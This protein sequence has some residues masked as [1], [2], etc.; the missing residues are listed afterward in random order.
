MYAIYMNIFQYQI[1]LKTIECGSF[2]RAADELHLTQSGVSHAIMALEEELGLTLLNRG[3]NGISLTSDGL[4]VIPHIKEICSVQHKLEEEIKDL[5]SLGTGMVRIGTF[6]S[7]SVWWLPGILRDFR[8]QW[9][10]IEFE[11]L[12]GDY[13]EIE[14]WISE[15][16]VDCGFLRLPTKQNLDCDPVYS[17][18]LVVLI[19]EDHPLASRKAISAQ[20]LTQYPYISPD[21]GKDYEIDAVFDFYKIKPR[22]QYTAKD[23]PTIMAMVGNGLGISIL[24]ELVVK[25]SS[26]PIVARP[27]AKTFRRDIGLCVR[28]RNSLSLST[29]FFLDFAKDWIRKN[30]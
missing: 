10:N 15:G 26:F 16:R 25:H 2:T 14:T 24:P 5:K 19:P 27:L 23:D 9:P 18:K 21:E 17:D 12:P 13:N 30:G 4:I 3:R 6:T 20:A 1:L 28:D 29:K 8:I 22:I 7:V 11:I